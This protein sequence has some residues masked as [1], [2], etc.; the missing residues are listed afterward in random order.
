MTTREQLHQRIR[1]IRILLKRPTIRYMYRI[2]RGAFYGQL[3]RYNMHEVA[4]GA[5]FLAQVSNLKIIANILS[6][7]TAILH[8]SNLVP[9]LTISR[10]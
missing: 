7:G 5:Y 10:S 8:K 1:L 6:P 2:S 3:L 4:K 9:V